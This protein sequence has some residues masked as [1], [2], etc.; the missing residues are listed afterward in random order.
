MIR[1][2]NNSFATISNRIYF[3][4]K[5]NSIVRS[6]FVSKSVKFGSECQV[7]KNVIIGENVEVGSY[8][9]FNS[10]EL[11]YIVVESGTKIGKFCSIAPNVFIGPGN[12]PLHFLTTHPLLFD[13]FWK[14]KFNLRNDS[15][16][17]IKRPGENGK[18]IIGNDVW[19]GTGSIITEGVKIGDGAVVA[20][21]SIVTKDV[22]PYSIVAG[23]PAKKISERFSKDN[24]NALESMHEKWWDFSPSFIKENIGYFYDV[25]AYIESRKKRN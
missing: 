7:A 6:P 9:Y 20:A 5:Y 18:V 19:I 16:P 2:V 11:G 25:N 24:V 14:N 17:S 21:G 22:S 13:D 10:H 4:K 23:I 12:H 15:L 8:T 3:K 1:Q